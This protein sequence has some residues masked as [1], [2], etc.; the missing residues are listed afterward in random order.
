M[1]KV[2][3]KGVVP[4]KRDMRWMLLI[5]PLAAC[6]WVVLAAVSMPMLQIRLTGTNSVIWMV[7]ALIASISI[8][9]FLYAG[10]KISAGACVVGVLT[11]IIYMAYVFTRN[12]EGRGIVGLVSGA[13][14]AALF[15]L[16]GV[17]IQMLCYLMN[18][19]SKR[20]E[21]E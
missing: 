1:Q 3:G 7:L 18:R 15:F 8:C 17:N 5:L 20:G 10:L 12:I 4:G 19:K 9:G 16:I 2:S 21:R 14:V 6:I 13:Q 11:G